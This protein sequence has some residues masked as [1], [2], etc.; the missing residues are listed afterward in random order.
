[1]SKLGKS[2]LFKKTAEVGKDL[3]RVIEILKAGGIAIIPSDTVF[4]PACRIDKIDAIRK[5]Y[6]IKKRPKNQP[7]LV[8]VNSIS[9][10]KK[11]VKITKSAN[12]LI[13][14][15]W[16]GPLTIIFTA[17]NSVPKNIQGK[18]GTLGVRYPNY[19]FILKIIK[20]VG[21]PI[22]APSANFKGKPP[23]KKFADL[24]EE[25][26]KRVDYVFEGKCKIGQESTVVDA[27][28]IPPKVIREGA[29]KL[30]L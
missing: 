14:K 30:N 5:L 20:K 3:E 11:Y 13:K 12:E 19:S 22:L 28:V 8:L 6:K 18:G 26:I 1:M 27:T 7:T 2:K 16:P 25:F 9:M 4:I 17:K 21:V 10:A 15:F 29:V 23:P 24:D